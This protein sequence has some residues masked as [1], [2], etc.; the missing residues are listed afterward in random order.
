MYLALVGGSIDVPVLR[1]MMKTQ[2]CGFGRVLGGGCR[3]GGS[4]VLCGPFCFSSF[5]WLVL[6]DD[7]GVVYFFSGDLTLAAVEEKTELLLTNHVA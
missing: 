6:M 7:V 4:G 1:M 3:L 2:V 5:I